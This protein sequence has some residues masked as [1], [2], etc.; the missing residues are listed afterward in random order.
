MHKRIYG[1]LFA[2]I[3][4]FNT[5]VS[6]GSV[7]ADQRGKGTESGIPASSSDAAE[8]SE[9]DDDISEEEKQ[10]SLEEYLENTN[11][12][13]DVIIYFRTGISDEEELK[14]EALR[15]QKNA[16]DILEKGS[17]EGKVQS[18][19]SFYIVNSIHAVTKDA[20]ILRAVAKLDEVEEIRENV[21]IKVEEPTVS[22]KS[23]VTKRSLT[24]DTQ[25]DFF[26][27]YDKKT[28]VHVSWALENLRAQKVWD[29]HKLDGSGITVGIMD[30]GVNYK[31]DA[32]KYSYK[33]YDE[34]TNTFDDS[35]YKDFTKARDK[36]VSAKGNFHGTMVAS[37][38]FARVQRENVWV[39]EDGVYKRYPK[40]T[41]YYGIVPGAKFISAKVLDG[42]GGP[43]SNFIEGGQWM[44]EQKPDIINN[45][46]GTSADVDQ[47]SDEIIRKMIANWKKAGIIIIFASGN[48][49]S[50]KAA[51]GSI[52]YPAKLDDVFSVGA[53]NKDDKI[54]EKSQRGPSPLSTIIKPDVVAPGEG[55][56]GISHEGREVKTNGTSFA[57]P[58]AAGTAALLKQANPNLSPDEIYE[59]LRK[60]SRALTDSD[61]TE[62]PN[63]TYGYG[64][65]DAYAAVNMA[66][67]KKEE[68]KPDKPK[69]E[70]QKPDKPKPEEQKPDNPKPDD[71]TN[72]KG[73]NEN[74]STGK[75]DSGSGSGSGSGSSSGGNSGG[76]SGSGS[77]GSSGRSSGSSGRVSASRAGG[78]SAAL[79]QSTAPSKDLII[80]KISYSGTWK[81][82][83][84]IWYFYD[85][86]G[87]KLTNAWV[88]T[89]NIW[90]ALSD[91][92][93]MVSG[94]WLKY[95]DKRYY[96]SENGS[97]AKG[98][99][100]YKSRWY[101]MNE[102]GS[103]A[104]GWLKYKSK[105]YYLD[106]D[107]AMLENTSMGEY[108]FDSEGAW[109]E[110]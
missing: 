72:P 47:A 31:L 17:L 89:N 56:L 86:S 50:G 96:M 16:L 93:A 108:K 80:N 58:Y 92:G 97:M 13:Y 46:W 78:V 6:S 43:I 69:P 53:I 84:N 44:L 98:W 110:K 68:K 24:E 79:V 49:P 65:V 73:G 20:D 36:S 67:G 1:A 30:T 81:S 77:G 34:K 103:M 100:K 25:E 76:G 39:I 82:E 70:E 40:D 99:L 87:N 51:T 21:T 94:T 74:P 101:Y 42:R 19:K 75:D 105:W 90:Y 61:N 18:Y 45:S 52:A 37:A 5:V 64:A 28:P 71:K 109:I 102:D 66:L 62:S 14:E 107:G 63:M 55:I 32:L 95:K 85:N 9:N 26:E 104:K 12:P 83:N 23:S 41:F 35:Y 2:F 33:G 48:Q 38:L 11:A 4:A 8:A 57:A 88:Y 10:K 27:T 7:M 106:N 22:K 3:L 60:T 15:E 54:W 59:I 29:E 91:S